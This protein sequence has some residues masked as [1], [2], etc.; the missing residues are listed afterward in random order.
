M[1]QPS[2]IAWVDQ[3]QAE[4][5]RLLDEFL[6][7]DNLR[8]RLNE[9][10]VAIWTSTIMIHILDSIITREQLAELFATAIARIITLEDTK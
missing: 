10:G 5:D 1:V 7:N 4:T 6:R 2:D 8:T 3:R 9:E